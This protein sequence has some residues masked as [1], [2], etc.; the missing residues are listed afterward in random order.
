MHRPVTI[1]GSTTSASKTSAG[2]AA[3]P[4]GVDPAAERLLVVVTGAVLRRDQDRAD[5]LAQGHSGRPG[6]CRIEPR[7]RSAHRGHAYPGTYPGHWPRWQTSRAVRW[8]L[9]HERVH[10]NSHAPTPPTPSTVP[11]RYAI[12]C[13]ATPPRRAAHAT[14]GGERPLAGR[15][16]EEDRQLRHVRPRMA[17]RPRSWSDHRSGRQEAPPP[18]EEPPAAT[19][20]PGPASTPGPAPRPCW[21]RG[22]QR[23]PGE[24]PAA[25]R[26]AC[27]GHAQ[28]AASGHQP[29]P[30]GVDRQ[31]TA[32]IEMGP[33]PKA[34]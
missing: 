25:P 27:V 11:R 18:A 10:Y 7:H 16:Q 30:I 32:A 31:L 26:T 20:P 28:S 34:G 13:A 29:S 22:R 6:R 14:P 19:P 21:P 33:C 4:V 17:P 3:V 8:L 9:N 12:P 1:G 24:R 5:G 2:A 23:S 15:A